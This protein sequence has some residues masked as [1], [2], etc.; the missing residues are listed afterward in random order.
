MRTTNHASRVVHFEIAVDDSARAI[1]FYE[2]VFD[3]KFEKWE[4]DTMEYWMVM[5][6]PPESTVPGINGGLFRRQQPK[7]PAGSAANAFTCVIEVTD[8]DAVTQKIIDAG[9]TQTALKSALPGMAWIGNF[10]DTEGNTFGLYQKDSN[11]K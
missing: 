2:S 5:S 3:C 11:A 4:T 9:G 10:L 1:A 7:A 8:F 6:A